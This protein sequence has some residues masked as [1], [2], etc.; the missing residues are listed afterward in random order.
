MIQG[1]AVAYI[2]DN[3]RANQSP[4][5][6]IVNPEPEQTFPAMADITIEVTARDP[7]GWVGLV[8]FF[9]GDTIIGED[10]IVFIQPP[11]PGLIQHFSMVWS[12]VPPG[13]H[14]SHRQGNR[15][16][17]SQLGVGRSPHPCG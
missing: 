16:H 17:G 6:A 11:P 14:R 9:D 15:Q 1:H 2:R 3:D 13:R 7:D 12:N 8:E 4:K 5:V 10:S